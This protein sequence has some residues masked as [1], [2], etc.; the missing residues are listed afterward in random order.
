MS[1]YK[2]IIELDNRLKDVVND[3]LNTGISDLI[4]FNDE[5]YLE[6]V[7]DYIESIVEEFKSELSKL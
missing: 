5:E 4:R 6:G 1:E 3:N 7:I 2:K